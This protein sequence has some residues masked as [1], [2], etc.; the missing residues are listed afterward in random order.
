MN[1]L[2][3]WLIGFIIFNLIVGAGTWKLFKN[4]GKEAWQAYVPFLNIWKGL[5]IIHRPK[6]WIILFYLPIVGP[7]F[8]LVY[9]VDLGDA[10]GKI[11]IKDKV[12]IALTLGLYLFAINYSDN[13]KYLGPEKRK[14]TFISSLIF[15]LVLATLVHN[16]FIQPMIVPTGSMENTIKIGDALFVEKVSHGA[17]VPFTPLGIPFSEFIYR[18]GF[19]DK[20]RLPYMRLPGWRDLKS[21]DIVVFNYPTDSVYS[22]IDRKDAYVK[23][24]VG[25]P[26]QTVQIRNGILYVDGKKFIPKKDAQVQHSY[27]VVVKTPFSEK[28]LYDNFGIISSDYAGSFGKNTEDNTF[29]YIFPALT[30]AHV[31]AMKSNTNVVSVEPVLQPVGS[32]AEHISKGKI[33]S[34]NTIFP[35]NKNWNPDQYGPLYIPKKGDVVDVTKETLPQFINIIRKYEHKSLRVDSANGKYDIFIDNQK[36]NKY[37]IEQN[38]YFMVGDNRNQSLDARFFGY[39]GEDHIIGRPI[40]IWANMNGMFEPA[41]PKKFIWNRFFTSINND[42]PNKTSYGIYVLIALAAWIGYDIVKARKDKKKNKY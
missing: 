16:W 25:L 15:A 27:K 40:M 28:L 39:V 10:Y 22:A 34:T 41:A 30:D 20:A 29:V 11:E 17:R 18:D 5:E 2:I 7:I 37:E 38:Y 42:N 14:P 35:V 1:I 12:I 31:T 36:T 23:R 8:W 6:W 3:Y 21:N 4:A 32:K 13:P 33:D 9:F 24:L 26:G 19:I